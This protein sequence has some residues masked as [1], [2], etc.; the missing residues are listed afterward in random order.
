MTR[1]SQN[2]L[3]QNL[4]IAFWGSL[5]SALLIGFFIPR[6]MAYLPGIIGLSFSIIIFIKQKIRLNLNKTEVI[7]FSSLLILAGLSTLWSPNQEFSFE[8]TLKLASIIIPALL[9]LKV[10]QFIKPFPQITLTKIIIGIH[11]IA[12]IFLIFE[13]TN[14]RIISGVIIDYELKAFHLNRSYVVFAF[15]SLFT[16]YM[17]LQIPLEKKKKIG[18]FTA[19]LILSIGALLLSGSQTSQLTFLC[20]LF[21]LIAF[22]IRIKK[23]GKALLISILVLSFALPFI[24]KPI[25]NTISE[26]V[27]TQ[28]ILGEAS[29]IYRFDVW[30]FTITEIEKNPLYGHGIEAQRFMKSDKWMKHQKSNTILHAHNAILQIWIEFGVI[31]ILLG[32]AF[33]IYFFKLIYKSDNLE[34][35]RLYM[36]F[37]TA[38]FCCA[39]TGYGIWQSWQIGT[40]LMFAAVATAI[41][42]NQRQLSTP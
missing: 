32:C 21:F 36:I 24:L 41:T 1:L 2:L 20:G 3:S 34:D 40:F 33:L 35:Q 30:D 13:Q 12:A 28:G 6:M 7:L 22:P 23:A 4:S 15:L 29:I 8:R 31:G 39:M 17:T 18:L 16:L 26:E 27:I 37:F 11:I 10:P 19:L 14:G 25:Q 42:N 5:I 9:L 38:S